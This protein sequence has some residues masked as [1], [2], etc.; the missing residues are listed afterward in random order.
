MSH[1]VRACGITTL[2]TSTSFLANLLSPIPALR[3]FGVFMTMCIWC[4]FFAVMSLWPPVLVL[5]GPKSTEKTAEVDQRTVTQRTALSPTE[6]FL[7][8]SLGPMVT[9]ARVRVL[10]LFAISAATCLFSTT[11]AWL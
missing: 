3:E 5:L 4:S 11:F 8:N 1:A 9:Q 10:M 6:S 2:A 7:Y